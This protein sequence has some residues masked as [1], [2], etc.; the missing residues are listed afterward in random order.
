MLI[1]LPL[2]VVLLAVLAALIGIFGFALSFIASFGVLVLYGLFW[3]LMLSVIPILLASRTGLLLLGQ[4]PLIGPGN[5][6]KAAMLYG[7]ALAVFTLVAMT[8]TAIAFLLQIDFPYAGFD[9]LGST[10]KTQMLALTLT[11]H[12]FI[13]MR[14][15]FVTSALFCIF[16]AALLVPMAAASIGRDMNGHRH[17]PMAGFGTGL[18]PLFALVV[19]GQT[20]SVASGDGYLWLLSQ[21]G[22]A[23]AYQTALAEVTLMAQGQIDPA[24]NHWFTVTLVLWVILSFWVL[25]LQSAGAALVFAENAHLSEVVIPA[26]KPIHRLAPQ[27]TRALWRSRMPDLREP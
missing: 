23:E 6:T 11:T 22:Y 25:S 26:A 1:M 24:W 27:E 19:V 2:L 20:I 5:L 8:V 7:F 4:K 10:A 12:Q 13:L 18:M 21:L 16:F 14:T 17:T 3:G 9:T 15:L